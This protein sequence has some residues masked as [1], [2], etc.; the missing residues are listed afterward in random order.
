VWHF[1]PYPLGVEESQLD[2]PRG[3]H[4]VILKDLPSE[5][6]LELACVTLLGS[7]KVALD[8]GVVIGRLYPIA[9]VFE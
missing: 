8:F 4:H 3:T 5:I 9:S 1:Y 6:V 2:G 7:A